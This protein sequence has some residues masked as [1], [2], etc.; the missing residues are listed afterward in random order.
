MT[1]QTTKRV[2]I[3]RL[4][5]PGLAALLLLGGC[6]RK[7]QTSQ[8]GTGAA[9]L[10]TPVDAPATPPASAVIAPERPPAGSAPVSSLGEN[11]NTATAGVVTT[12]DRTFLMTAARSG[13]TEIAAS[14][15]ATERARNDKIK[16]FAQTM[17]NDYTAIDKE[18]KALA[19][20][21]GVAVPEADPGDQQQQLDALSRAKSDAFD[22][23]YAE[24][25]GRQAPRDAVTLFERA[26][27]EASDR[28]VRAFAV[29]TLANLKQHL[30]MAESLP[31]TPEP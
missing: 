11:A 21:K 9:P 20:R 10:D 31:R 12:A 3:A 22:G 6:D 8:A 7:Q 25:I 29:K 19:T 26:A 18:L 1:P 24:L 4:V 28:D 13:Y 17:L 30:A 16:S 14:K 27:T 2:A 5:V 15:L 23:L